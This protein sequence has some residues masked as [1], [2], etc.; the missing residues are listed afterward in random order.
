[1]NIDE[2]VLC[3]LEK[4]VTHSLESRWGISNFAL[5]RVCAGLALMFYV[6]GTW[7][8]LPVSE[9]A[10]EDSVFDKIADIFMVFFNVL[11][12]FMAE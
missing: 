9:V 6:L 11:W 5:A 3:F 1:M 8:F 4:N 7:E 2:R 10:L 12:L